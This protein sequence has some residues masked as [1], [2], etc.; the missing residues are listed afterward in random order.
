MVISSF[1]MIA[2][3]DI[4]ALERVQCFVFCI[5][6][7]I[8]IT[9]CNLCFI[10]YVY[11]IVVCLR[12]KVRFPP[13]VSNQDRSVGRKSR[14]LDKILSTIYRMEIL[15][16][17]YGKWSLRNADLYFRIVEGIALRYGWV[18]ILFIII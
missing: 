5:S 16:K 6:H 2:Q 10:Y 15:G 8:P 11:L 17:T 13:G 9:F 4:R 7:D 18:E 3:A 1:C 12:Q 14:F